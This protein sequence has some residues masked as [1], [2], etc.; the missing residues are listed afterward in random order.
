MLSR[1]TFYEFVLPS[2]ALFYKFGH[3]KALILQCISLAKLA[4]LHYGPFLLH[5]MLRANH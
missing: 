3:F 2:I 4:V 5:K 1:D